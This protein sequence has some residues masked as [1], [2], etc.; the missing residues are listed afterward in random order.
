MSMVYYISG[1][2]AL[3]FFSMIMAQASVTKTFTIQEPFGLTWTA[4]RV[5]YPVSFPQGAVAPNGVA[6]RDAANAPVAVQLSDITFWPD[7]KT[8]KTAT[9]SFMAALQPDE[10]ATWTLI[11]GTK[12]VTQPATD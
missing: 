11:A 12:P 1:L 7:R 2:L 9:V 5:D 4:D 8:V 3:L 6:L 10:A